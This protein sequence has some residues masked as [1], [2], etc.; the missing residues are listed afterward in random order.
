M[1]TSAGFPTPQLRCPADGS[2][3]RA[4]WETG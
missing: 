4:G 3:R 1:G 2:G